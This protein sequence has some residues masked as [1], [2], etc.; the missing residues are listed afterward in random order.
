MKTLSAVVPIL[1]GLI[2]LLSM[3]WAVYQWLETRDPN[4]GI[5]VA[6]IIIVAYQ[7]DRKP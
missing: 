4:Y 1:I 5:L 3:W 2:M 7:H 6:I